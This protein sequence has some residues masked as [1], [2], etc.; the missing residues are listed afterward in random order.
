MA[1]LFCTFQEYFI[2]ADILNQEVKHFSGGS[3]GKFCIN[4]TWGSR[5]SYRKNIILHTQLHL[6]WQ[7]LQTHCYITEGFQAVMHQI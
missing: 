4:K 2:Y 6:H 1:T 7:S 5:S 3:E